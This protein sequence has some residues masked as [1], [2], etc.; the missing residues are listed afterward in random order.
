MES[1]SNHITS[2]FSNIP[3]TYRQS[4]DNTKYSYPFNY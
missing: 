2:I 3:R 1:I 4:P